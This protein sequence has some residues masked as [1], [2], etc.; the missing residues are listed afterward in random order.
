MEPTVSDIVIPS[1]SRELA[2]RI[3]AGARSTS[4]QRGLVFVHGLDSDQS[5]YRDRALAA[6]AELDAVCLTFDLSGHGRSTGALDE[7][8]ARDH[9]GDVIAVTDALVGQVAVDPNRLGVCGASYGA[10]L[11]ALLR[12]ER[13]V[14]RLLLRAPALYGDDVFDMPIA[15]RRGAPQRQ[16]SAKPLTVLERFHADGSHRGVRTR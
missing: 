11:A 12:A 1:G 8:S 13:P 4:R 7:L 2:A 14:Q 5:G 16:Q 6:A 3:I 9:L 15:D 10:Y